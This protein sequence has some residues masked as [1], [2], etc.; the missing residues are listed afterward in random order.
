MVMVMF[1]LVQLVQA[2]HLD[3]APLEVNRLHPFRLSLVLPGQ[4]QVIPVLRVFR[5]PRF[6]A[7]RR[8]ST[9]V[10]DKGKRDRNQHR[11]VHQCSWD[12]PRRRS[13]QHTLR[14]VCHRGRKG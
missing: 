3:L 7:I 10:Q 4:Y 13:L 14:L 9:V 5:V 12:Q 11:I 6:T 1:P 8:A 2:Q